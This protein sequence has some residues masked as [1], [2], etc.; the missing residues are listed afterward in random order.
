[1]AVNA[2][3]GSLAGSATSTYMTDDD[4]ILVGEALP[5]SLKLMES[6]LEETPEHEGLLIAAASGFVQYGHAYVLRPAEMMEA[7]DLDASRA[8]KVRAG[9]LFLR[10]L[11]YAGR[12]LEVAHPGIL[13]ELDSAPDSAVNRFEA[14]DV[15]GLYWY[16]A[17]LG[18]A[19]S[20][21]RGEMALVADLPLVYLLLNRSL[22]L[23]EA[24]NRG[25]L[26][27]IM[28]ALVSERPEAEGGGSARAEM[29]FQR[30]M[31]LNRGRSISPM[32][33]FAE[34][35]CVQQ[36]DRRQFESLLNEVLAFDAQADEDFRLANLLAQQRAAWL[37]SR[38]DELF[39]QDRILMVR[40]GSTAR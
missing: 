5:F 23:D 34:S 25:A 26:H 32:V 13:A 39:F 16:A 12:A 21:D 10:A 8:G 15:A 27:E 28:I 30:A 22:E 17:A 6:I 4:P 2:V 31:E 40:G 29:H 37:L 19:I 3:A 14:G 7:T 38:I 36:Q 20:A 24:W 18:S 35:V 11:G 9:R 33:L 1:M